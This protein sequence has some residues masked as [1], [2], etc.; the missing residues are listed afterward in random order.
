MNQKTF[1]AY[2][3][4]SKWHGTLYV[5]M[6]NNLTRRVQEHKE[7]R[8]SSFTA[9]YNVDQ[10]VYYTSYDNS[11]EAVTMEKRLKRWNRDWKIELIEENNPDWKDLSLDL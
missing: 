8:C 11:V 7:K 3:L 6:T 10:L 2:I 5:G 9:K 1:Y 4:A